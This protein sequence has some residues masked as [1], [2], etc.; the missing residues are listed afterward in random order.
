MDDTEQA[1]EEFALKDRLADVRARGAVQRIEHGMTEGHMR[2][3][4]NRR[5]RKPES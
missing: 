1:C 3:G 5:H 4:F 2:C